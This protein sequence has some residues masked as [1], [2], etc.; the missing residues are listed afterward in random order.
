MKNYK[1]I[2]LLLMLLV[3]LPALA[4]RVL[5]N[6]DNS[7]DGLYLAKSAKNKTKD[8]VYK[9]IEIDIEGKY[10]TLRIPAEKRNVV[11][12]IQQFYDWS[13]EMELTGHDKETN[14][15]W[16]VKYANSKYGPDG[17]PRQ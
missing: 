6:T 10:A 17:R 14:D 13:Y 4:G 8:Q 5:E 9:K 15:Y 1:G 2:A 16:I 7:L 12:R 3:A 11:L